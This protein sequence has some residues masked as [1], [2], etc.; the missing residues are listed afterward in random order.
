MTVPAN[1]EVRVAAIKVRQNGHDL[2]MAD[3]TAEVLL[4]HTKVDKWF[5]TS[6]GSNPLDNGYQREEEKPH[7]N[8]VGVYLSK[9][10]KAILPTSVL[11]CA[12]G[13]VKF[14]PLASDS[15]MG[16]LTISA[17]SLPLYIVDGQHRIAG[18][19][20]AIQDLGHEESRNFT[21]PAVIMA[22]M[23][24]F[25]EVYQFYLVNST[26]KKIKTD[27]AQRLLSEMASKDETIRKSVVGAGKAWM[28]RA[29]AISE[30]LNERAGSPWEGRIQR[31]NARKVGNVMISESSFTASLRPILTIPWVQKQSNEEI[32]E[33]ISRYWL[34]ICKFLPEACEN[35]RDYALQKT[36]GVY[37]WHMVAPAIFEI[38]RSEKDFSVQRMEKVLKQVEKGGFLTDDYWASGTGEATQ[39]SSSAGFAILADNILK[40]LPYS[41]ALALF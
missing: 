12:R 26:S 13:P 14:E 17:P 2:Y 28:L 27:L 30:L 19:R 4:N 10:S 9:N 8:K 37:P 29:V 5:S 38:C 32:A 18:L 39:F 40:E 22:G 1:T 41:E 34:A 20:H 25:D 16:Y 36:T 11:L 23:K 3:L 31:P 24:K 15:T 6:T 21:I 35:P 7:Y 33:I